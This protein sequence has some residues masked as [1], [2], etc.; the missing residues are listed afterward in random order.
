VNSSQRRRRE[1]VEEL[2]E[3]CMRNGIT[4]DTLKSAV[5]N[6][7]T[8]AVRR[9]TIAFFDAEARA[10]RINRAGLMA[11]LYYLLDVMGPRVLP[12]WL[13]DQGSVLDGFVQGF[14]TSAEERELD[15]GRD[16]VDADG[17]VV[18]D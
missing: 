4:N 6:R 14:S 18:I 11:Q 10:D 2:I 8:S 7:V 12:K 1:K 5:Q 16:N 15:V 13:E 17:C 3:I 9:D